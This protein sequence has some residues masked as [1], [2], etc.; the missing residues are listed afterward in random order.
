MTDSI[1]ILTHANDGKTMNVASN[2][3]EDAA[4]LVDLSKGELGFKF[5]NSSTRYLIVESV[6]TRDELV[7]KYPSAYESVQMY[8]GRAYADPA[9]QV[10]VTEK[11]IGLLTR[12]QQPDT[13]LIN[14]QGQQLFPAPGK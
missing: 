5:N 10:F 12:D 4:K 2:R 13:V 14:R 7:S 6:L 1:T 9:T 11:A 8:S 3:L